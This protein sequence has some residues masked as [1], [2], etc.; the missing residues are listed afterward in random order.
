[1]LLHELGFNAITYMPS[2]NTT[3]QLTR[4]RGLCKQYDF[5]EISGEDINSPRQSFICMAQRA[6]EFAHLYAATMALIG[7]ERAAT[8]RL[9][10]AMFSA[11][12]MTALPTLEARIARY[13]DLATV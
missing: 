2:R 1:M 11:Q 13:A 12:S 8:R 4:L 7:H 9:N 3:E 6:P 10:D 5:F